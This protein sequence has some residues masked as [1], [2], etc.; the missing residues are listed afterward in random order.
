MELLLGLDIGTTAVKAGV[1]DA[2]M[3]PVASSQVAYRRGLVFPRQGWVEHDAADLWQGVIEAVRAVASAAAGKGEIV[4]LSLSTQGGTTIVLDREGQALRPAISWMDTRAVGAELGPALSADAVYRLTGWWSPSGLPLQ[5]IAWLA[6]NEPSLHAQAARFAFV[7]DYIIG[8]MTGEYATDPSN[9]AIT[10][11]Y[12]LA[13]QAWQHALL[14][15]AHVTP[16]RLPRIAPSGAP[17][18]RLR[19]A[20]AGELGLPAGVLVANGA[21]D[22]YCAALGCGVVEPGATLIASGTAWVIFSATKRPVFDD[23]QVF[24]PGPHAIA[25]RWGALSS[26]PSAGASVEWYL[27]QMGDKAGAGAKGYAWLNEGAQRSLVGAKGLLFMPHLGGFYSAAGDR[28]VRGAWVGLTLGHTTGDLSRSLM[29]GVAYEVRRLVELGQAAGIEEA[30]QLT[31]VGGAASSPVWPAILAD[32]LGRPL[33][34]PQASNAACRGAGILA[35]VGAGI[36]SDAVAGAGL[37]QGS[38]TV[39]SPDAAHSARY[40]ELYDVYCDAFAR[41]GDVF[42]AL[43]R[44]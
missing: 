13:D 37:E 11:L 14:A 12:G 20:V 19:P 39:F 16:S 22:Q 34:V 30:G 31:M 28:P 42:A 32:V 2:R 8:R 44:A 4:S 21:H 35:G 10:M 24:H 43:S 3:Q 18:G 27:A 41:L 15:A 33:A 1:F 17:I 25:G 9:A 40:G 7:S 38:E 6:A 36:L 29:E 26:L 23:K 5:H